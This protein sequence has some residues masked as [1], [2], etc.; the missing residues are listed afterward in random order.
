MTELQTGHVTRHVTRKM[1]VPKTF[2]RNGN[3]GSDPDDSAQDRSDVEERSGER[4]VEWT[5]ACRLGKRDSVNEVIHRVSN[6]T[7][8]RDSSPED[9]GVHQGCCFSRKQRCRRST[10]TERKVD[11]ALF[12]VLTM[13]IVA[14]GV[15]VVF[16]YF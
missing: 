7:A 10:S 12:V 16:A 14:L 8:N 2:S 13:W 4:S 6:S 9:S 11:M 3:L 15:G 5:S 1:T